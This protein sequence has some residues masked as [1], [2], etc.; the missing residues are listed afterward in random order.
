MVATVHVATV[1]S[2]IHDEIAVTNVR[3]PI[4]PLSQWG[5]A[6]FKCVVMM[7]RRFEVSRE[8]VVVVR[9]GIDQLTTGVKFVDSEPDWVD[10][11]VLV[12]GWPLL[13]VG[14]PL[15]VFHQRSLEFAILLIADGT[16]RGVI[17][18]IINRHGQK[19]YS[20][21]YSLLASPS[22]VTNIDCGLSIES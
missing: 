10:V 12:C 6:V 20:S 9:T 13:D 4:F 5:V 1:L 19:M 21:S 2:R 15:F 8:G 11:P 17:L 16:L 7:F 14:F 3:I 22:M 18:A